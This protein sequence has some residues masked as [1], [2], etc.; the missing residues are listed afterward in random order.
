MKSIYKLLLAATPVLFVAACGG[1]DDSI[2]DRLDI[3]D[4]KVRFVHA[5]PAGP[6][7]DFLRGPTVAGGVT[8]VSYRYASKY[9]VVDT[10]P[11]DYTVRTTAGASTIATINV[12]PTRGNKY[13]FIAMPGASTTNN[14]LLIND[15]YD[16]QL[17]ATN[18]RVRVVNGSFNAANV[19]VYL[20]AP[21]VD[22]A[23]VGPNF[24]AAAYGTSVPGSGA[25]S[26]DFTNGSYQLRVTTAGTKNV[27]FSA[28]LAV[29]TNADLLLVTI[30]ATL[31]ANSVKVLSVIADNEQPATELLTQP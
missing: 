15:P 31:L 25:N 23:T 22:I 3:A 27:I 20:T 11:A 19:D 12:N 29:A 28:P 7:V 8:N 1:G 14:L 5:I 13:T 21:T 18:G 6:A 17:T 30:P 4:P 2:D 9:F 24:A 10:A 26:I 16:K